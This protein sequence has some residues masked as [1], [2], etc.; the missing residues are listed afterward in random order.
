MGK[1]RSLGLAV[2][3]AGGLAGLIWVADDALG[4]QLGLVPSLVVAL[5]VTAA[6]HLLFARPRRKS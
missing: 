6:V 1:L 5:F 3:L 4:W 2:L